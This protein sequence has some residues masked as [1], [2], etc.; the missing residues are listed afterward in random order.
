MEFKCEHLEVPNICQKYKC[1]LKNAWELLLFYTIL[2]VIFGWRKF[3]QFNF[4]LY[5]ISIAHIC[6]QFYNLLYNLI[7]W[8]TTMLSWKF[9]IACVARCFKCSRLLGFFWLC[10]SASDPL[11]A[12]QLPQPLSQESGGR[13]LELPN[14]RGEANVLI[15]LSVVATG[16]VVAAS[17][18]AVAN[19]CCCRLLFSWKMQLK[20][21]HQ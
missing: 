12:L 8:L 19:F 21:Q 13:S 5:N 15:L 3:E 1:I 11:T 18:V 17:V 10:Y 9:Q 14:F 16:V 7:L 20:Q 2:L 6:V 4:P